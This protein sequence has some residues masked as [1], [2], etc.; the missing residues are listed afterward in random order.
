MWIN[1]ITADAVVVNPLTKTGHALC[2]SDTALS[3][4]QEELEY[5]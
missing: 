1:G 3:A 2:L 5:A 4:D